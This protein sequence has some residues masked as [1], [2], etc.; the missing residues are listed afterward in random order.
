MAHA[1][2]PSHAPGSLLQERPLYVRAYPHPCTPALYFGPCSLWQRR[3]WRGRGRQ[4]QQWRRGHCSLHGLRCGALSSGGH[5]GARPPA[6]ISMTLL[7]GAAA[8][9]YCCI[10][11]Y[12][13]LGDHSMLSTHSM[14]SSQ[15]T[16]DLGG[17]FDAAPLDPNSLCLWSEVQ[18]TGDYLW[19][20]RLLFSDTRGSICQRILRSYLGVPVITRR[21][22][23]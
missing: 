1:H 14:L 15:C 6:L 2:T 11:L 20:V 7:A 17:W 16:Q 12:A 22:V 23:L 18:R 19:L 4:Q 21:C 3:R 5:D 8:A 13:L 9:Y 10:L